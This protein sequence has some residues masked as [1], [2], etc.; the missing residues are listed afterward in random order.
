MTAPNL[1]VVTVNWNAGA[2]L[3]D[4]LNSFVA[5]AKPGPV[6]MV[7]VDNA[8]ADGS[9]RI[10][11]AMAAQGQPVT[12]VRAGENLGFAKGCNLG[13]AQARIA[14]F[15]PD[16]VLFLNPDTRLEA[17]T[18]TRLFAA[19]CL[20]D[21]G[22]GIVGI[23]L[24]D[25]AGIATSCSHFPTALNF[26]CKYTGLDR[27]LPH[28]AWA[29]HHMRGFDHCTS[30]DVDQVMGAFLMVRAALFDRLGGFDPQFFVYFEEVDLCL[31]ARRAGYRVWFESGSRA[32]HKGGGTTEG[33]KGFRLYLSLSS[34]LRY[35]RK[36]RAG[37][38]HIAVQVLSFAVEPLAR[39]ARLLLRGQPGELKGLAEGYG[40]MIRYGIR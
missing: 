12:L 27:L 29:Q 8:S 14:G 22:I 7:V 5:A 40:L 18:L 11:E 16:F 35:F 31:R 30:R 20:R 2:H 32:W 34:R 26:W 4:C 38:S 33:A 9:E 28:R 1:L 39:A 3:A 37:L 25:D 15:D 17:D 21:P 19:D 23:Q 24:V 10:A 36:N 6:H 13:V